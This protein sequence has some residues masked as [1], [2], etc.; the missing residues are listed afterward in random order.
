MKRYTIAT[1]MSWRPCAGNYPETRVQALFA[2]RDTLTAQDIA[3]LKIYL[4]TQNR[5]G[6]IRT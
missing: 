1:V 2:G 3:A 6:G 5:I 4:L